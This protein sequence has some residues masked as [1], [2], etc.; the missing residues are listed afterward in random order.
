MIVRFLKAFLCLY[1]WLETRA[2]INFKRKISSYVDPFPRAYVFKVIA[3]DYWPNQ[4][5]LI[6]DYLRYNSTRNRALDRLLLFRV[7]DESRVLGTRR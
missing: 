6:D 2:D 5:Q 4:E 3:S 1:D 7:L